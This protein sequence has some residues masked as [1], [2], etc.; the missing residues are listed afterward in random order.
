[1][2]NC[3]DSRPRPSRPYQKH[4]F[5]LSVV[6]ADISFPSLPKVDMLFAAR[7]FDGDL[8]LD[9]QRRG[10]RGLV[11]AG[12]GSGSVPNADDQIAEALE[13]GL[14]IVVA[15]RSPYGAA[16]PEREPTVAKSGYVQEIQSRIM[17]ATCNRFW[18]QSKP[19][20]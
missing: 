8:I 9:S 5:D 7:Q 3:A 18:F 12:T 11:I 15:T 10:A 17:V 14:Q 1:M 20:Y 2:E 4:E 13:N 6:S 16:T 19:D